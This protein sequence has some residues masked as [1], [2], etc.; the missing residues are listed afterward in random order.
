MM[1][2]IWFDMFTEAT[3]PWV[4]SGFANKNIGTYRR[5]WCFFIRIVLA[6]RNEAL[7]SEYKPEKA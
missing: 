5:I 2:P 3:P 6:T 4:A 7:R 1:S